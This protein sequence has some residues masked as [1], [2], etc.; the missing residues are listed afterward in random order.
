MGCRHGVINVIYIYELLRKPQEKCILLD[1]LMAWDHVTKWYQIQLW[2]K[3]YI[4]SCTQHHLH[5]LFYLDSSLEM[6]FYWEAPCNRLLL[7][8]VVG[9]SLFNAICIPPTPQKSSKTCN[10]VSSVEVDI[11][12][13]L[14]YFATNLKYKMNRINKYR[15]VSPIGAWA[16]R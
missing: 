16:Y 2:K 3:D 1:L 14:S 12:S 7:Q 10:S 9:H 11:L 8:C 13:W 15:I 5:W 6:P 4:G